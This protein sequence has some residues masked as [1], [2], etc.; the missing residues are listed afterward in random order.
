ML[1]Q[2]VEEGDAETHYDLGLA[3]KEMGLY[4][5]AV[6]AFEKALRAPSREVNCRVMIGMCHREQG[7]ASE[8]ITQFKAGLHANPSEREQLS[9]Y[10]EIAQTYESIGDD[11]EALYYYDSV[12]KRDPGFADCASRSDLLRARVARGG[13]RHDADDDI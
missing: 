5:D 4:D 3:Y 1:G 8:A 10:Y 12:L 11:A 6:K 9:L 13:S 7:N 2:A